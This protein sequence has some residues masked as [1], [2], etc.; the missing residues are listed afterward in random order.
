MPIFL[1]IHSFKTLF[2]TLLHLDVRHTVI[3]SMFYTVCFFTNV[4]KRTTLTLIV[5]LNPFEY[6]H[7]QAKNIS[8][9]YLLKINFRLVNHMQYK[10]KYAY[11]QIEMM[12]G[13]TKRN[14]HCSILNAKQIFQYLMKM[15]RPSIIQSAD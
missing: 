4:W 11:S 14:R 5:Q 7:L 12:D 10:C 2:S 15:V 9:I 6:H 13:F 8:N 3:E 1:W